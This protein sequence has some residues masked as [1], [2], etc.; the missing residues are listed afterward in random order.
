MPALFAILVFSDVINTDRRLSFLLA[1]SGLMASHRL[2]TDSVMALV[3]IA[4]TAVSWRSM[5]RAIKV[6]VASTVVAVVFQLFAFTVIRVD[7][8]GSYIAE[9]LNLPQIQ[10]NSNRESSSHQSAGNATS[11]KTDQRTRTQPPWTRLRIAVYMTTHQ[12]EQHLRF[13]EKCWPYATIHLPLLQHADL[14]YYYAP[15]TPIVNDPKGARNSNHTALE[16]P[17]RVLKQLHFHNITVRRYENRGY[18]VGAK[19]AM[20]DPFDHGWF[21][22]YDWIVHLNPDV[23]IRNDTWFLEQMLNTSVDALFY[24][25]V[26]PFRV[27]SDF[28]AFRPQAANVAALKKNLKTSFNAESQMGIGFSHV[29]QAGRVTWIPHGKRIGLAARVVGKTSYVIHE[30][31]LVEHCPNY[32][33]ASGQYY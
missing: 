32:F 17:I 9:G 23:L 21:D 26:G 18:Q 11:S 16:P 7:M 12:S 1:P 3:V 27:H 14:I 33:N 6:V 25:C 8:I 5:S 22:G 31:S 19:Q 29:I 13:L 20:V 4:G 24:R 10:S 30:H 2:A 15:Y 28:T